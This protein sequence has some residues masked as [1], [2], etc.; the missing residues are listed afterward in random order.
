[1]NLVAKFFLFLYLFSSCIFPLEIIPKENN[2]N[3]I[4]NLSD[5]NSDLSLNNDDYIL[6]PGDIF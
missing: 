2:D 1:M 3:L 5:A 4:E 6:G